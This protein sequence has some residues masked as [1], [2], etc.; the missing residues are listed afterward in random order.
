MRKRP[1]PLRRFIKPSFSYLIEK[2]RDGGEF[3][4][5]EIRYIIDSTLDG[6]MP[7]HQLAALLM[8]V[9]FANM[10]AQET[11]ILTEEMM[12]SGEVIDLSHIAKP[13]IDKYS[14]GGV[15]DK[16]SLVLV[17]LAMASGVVVPMMCGTD[18]EYVINTLD[19]LASIPGFK[20]VQTIPHF[21]EQ[22]EQISG[23]I[24]AQVP[25][26]APADAKFYELR[27]DTGTIPSLPLITGSVLSRKLAEG[28][29]G[30]VIDVKWGNGSFIRDLEQAKQ[31][32]RSMTRVGRSMK[33]RCVALVTDM[34][35]PLGDTVGTS[36]EV[37]EA[38]TLLKGGGPEDMKELVLKLGMEIVRLAGVAG[39]TLSAKQTV[40]R[41]LSDG[42]A[43][44]KFKELVQ[45]QGGD[46]SYIDHPEKFPQAKHIRKLP[47]PKRGYVHTINAAMIARGVHLLGAGRQF[48]HDKIDYAVGVS[49]I[50]KVGTQVK[51]GEPL[52][53]IHYDDEAKL[54]QSLE[55]FKNA[56]RLAP[57]RP[58][59]P[60]LI[61]ERVA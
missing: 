39:S 20:G 42:S 5:E 24:A 10:S 29:E 56:Y 26:L 7:Q 48:S 32:A 16:T 53:M 1:L 51:Q 8:A 38:I 27:K 44:E 52:M 6:E 40:Q 46:V 23:A 4:Q 47:A 25:D 22:L 60:P 2:K 19:Q 21:V 59:P 18:Q 30:L 3:S 45:A 31:L 49:E 17:P 36:L 43:L 34:N 37:K 11:A 58:T 41:H 13:K 15:G 61:V 14:T 50:K 28:S 55:Y 12:L 57:K 54:E 9:Y 33:R 35:Q